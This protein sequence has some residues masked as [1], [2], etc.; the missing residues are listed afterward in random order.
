ME[1]KY[2]SFFFN[3]KHYLVRESDITDRWPSISNQS[4]EHIVLKDGFQYRATN[5]KEVTFLDLSSFPE[6]SVIITDEPL[7]F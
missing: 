2:I 6:R 1:T 3:A 5:I 7:D 4:V